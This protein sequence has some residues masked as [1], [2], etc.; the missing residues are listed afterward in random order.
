M[1]VSRISEIQ[2]ADVLLACR[3]SKSSM[4]GMS[5]VPMVIKAIRW[6]F[7][8]LQIDSLSVSMG[9]I[10]SA[11]QK[12]ISVDRRESLPFSLF[13][14]MHFERRILM[15][16]CSNSEVISLGMCLFLAFSGLRFSDMQRTRTS[17]LHWS[18]SVLREL[19]GALRRLERA[20]LL[21]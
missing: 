7:C 15:R 21:G 18:G 13:V 16:E 3:L 12:G 4:Q 20:N 9:S 8:T 14:L 6:A 2:L 11:F 1:D 5:H 19:A 10:I 17:S